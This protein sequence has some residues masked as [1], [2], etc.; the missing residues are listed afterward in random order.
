MPLT[1]ELNFRGF[2]CFHL[3]LFVVTMLIGRCISAFCYHKKQVRMLA[4][5]I[6]RKQVPQLEALMYFGT[7][8][9]FEVLIFYYFPDN[10]QQYP[11]QRW[12]LFTCS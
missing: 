5:L 8:V 12:R 1:G 10:L 2:P 4:Y 3:P 11:F 7:W 9:D 6:S